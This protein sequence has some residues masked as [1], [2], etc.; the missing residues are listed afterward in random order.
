MT[1]SVNSLFPGIRWAERFSRSVSLSFRLFVTL[2]ISSHS[3]TLTLYMSHHLAN[4]RHIGYRDFIINMP[5]NHRMRLGRNTICT[6]F[7]AVYYTQCLIQPAPYNVRLIYNKWD[8]RTILLLSMAQR[9]Y[10]KL[11]LNIWHDVYRTSLR[12]LLVTRNMADIFMKFL[13]E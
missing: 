3:L 2:P 7:G 1:Y 12:W 13:C 11:Q 8:W 10:M 6:M 4:L 9:S 5:E